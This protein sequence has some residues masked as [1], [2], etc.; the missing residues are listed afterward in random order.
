[1]TILYGVIEFKTSPKCC[2][3]V[4]CKNCLLLLSEFNY[5]KS[6]PVSKWKVGSKTKLVGPA[7]LEQDLSYVR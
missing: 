4:K 3:K 1:M 7:T 6:K 5:I 2:K